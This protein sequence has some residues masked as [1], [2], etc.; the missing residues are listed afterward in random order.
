M[1][2]GTLLGGFWV[3]SD[4]AFG[5]MRDQ[6]ADIGSRLGSVSTEGTTTRDKVADI[7]AQMLAQLQAINGQ[8]TALNGNIGAL[9]IRVDGQL[10]QLQQQVAALSQQFEK[11]GIEKAI[12]WE[13]YFSNGKDSFERAAQAPA[14]AQFIMLPANEE[15][16]KFL[17]TIKP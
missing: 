9:T 5:G 7:Q 17:K 13:P 4:V 6:V 11:A 14:S 1:L 2:I 10:L 8:M 3:V 16:S 12:Q 15:A